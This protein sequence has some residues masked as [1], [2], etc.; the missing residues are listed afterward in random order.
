MVLYVFVVSYVGGRSASRCAGG[1]PR[2]ARARA[3]PSAALFAELAIAILG[4]GL[5]A[6]DGDGA[7]V[8]RPAF[9]T[10]GA[11]RPSCC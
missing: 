1:G 11:D 9:G 6:L 10:P 4:T 2:A 3:S 5:K 8:R 7:P